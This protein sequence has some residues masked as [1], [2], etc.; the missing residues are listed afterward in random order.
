MPI[1]QSLD[2][3]VTRAK[4]DEGVQ[5]MAPL[6]PLEFFETYEVFH[7]AKKGGQHTHV[8]SVHAPNPEMAFVFAKEQYTR[9]NVSA[10]LW[11]VRTSDV[12]STSYEDADM[13]ESTPEKQYREP[14]FYK[15][16]AK[17]EKFKKEHANKDS[18]H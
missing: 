1:I 16:R 4:I 8:G 11:V 15:V 12:Y 17:I 14:G 10:N 2:P 9:R 18:E 6:E 3:R 7:Q 5:E 13:Y